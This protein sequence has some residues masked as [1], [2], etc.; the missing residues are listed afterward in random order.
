MKNL[1]SLID[2]FEMAHESFIIGCDSIE[3]M[4]LW[5]KNEYGEME[6][7]YSNDL[8]SVIIRLIATDGKITD[9][10]VAYLDEIFG[11]QYDTDEL[12]EV[13]NC[14][15]DDIGNSFDEAFENG[16]TILRGINEKLANT[17]KR[18]LGLVCEIIIECDGVI[19]ASEAEEVK[20][21]K[22]MCD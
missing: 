2:A 9:K 6:A 18:L 16:I 12:R 8:V 11:F 10:E 3:E 4:G 7:F 21:L 5:N 17:Y 1:Q 22:A 15:Q 13:Y 14:C 20:K 19:S